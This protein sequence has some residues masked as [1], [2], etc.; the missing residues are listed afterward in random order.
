MRNRLLQTNPVAVLTLIFM[1]LLSSTAITANA[2]D[3]YLLQYKFKNGE[4]LQYKSER[5]DSTESTGMGGGASVREMTIWS[6]QTL[7]V[8]DAKMDEYFKFSIKNDSTWTDQ[9]QSMGEGMGMGRGMGGGRGRDHRM[10]GGGRDRSYEIT[11]NGKSLSKDPPT[12][13]FLIPLPEKAIAVNETWDFE[14]VSEQKGRMQG[15]TTITGQ[16]LLFE[17]QKEGDLTLAIIIVNS[18]TKSDGKLN[19]QMQGMDPVTGSYNRSISAT[20]LVY[21]D[22]DKGRIIEVVGEET[23]ESVTESSMFSSDSRSKAKTNVILVSE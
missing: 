16:C 5:H 4:K 22:V 20:N 23:S 18:Q 11:P 2:Q 9:D 17:I 10:G 14:T 6:L 3:N 8:E 15:K 1:L 19:F 12:F 13:P 21:F 7:S